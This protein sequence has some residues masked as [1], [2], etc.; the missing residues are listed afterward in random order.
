[1]LE[2]GEVPFVPALSHLPLGALRG[3]G[4][5]SP[6]KQSAL[7]NM[8]WPGGGGEGILCPPCFLC[9]DTTFPACLAPQGTRWVEGNGLLKA[10]QRAR[11]QI[12]EDLK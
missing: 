6:P 11:P 1:M 12:P 9:V 8:V 4:L 7:G 2:A 3:G 5:E 10:L